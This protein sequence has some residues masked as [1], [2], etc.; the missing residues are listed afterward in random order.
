MSLV[1]NETHTPILIS[2]GRSSLV[3]SV[4]SLELLQ[5]IAARSR[6][7]VSKHPKV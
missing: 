4:L 7:E 3:L 2:Y 5:S 1:R 6:V